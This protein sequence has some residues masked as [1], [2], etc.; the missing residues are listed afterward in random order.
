MRLL[1]VTDLWYQTYESAVDSIFK[2]YLKEFIEVQIVYLNNIES[3]DCTNE[4]ILIDKRKKRKLVNLININ[5]YEYI[6]IR[7]DFHILN[8]FLSKKLRSRTKT[9]IGFQL[10]FPHSYRRYYEAIRFK[11]S[12]LRKKIEYLLK[13]H[14]E[15]HLINKCDFFLPITREMINVF[16]SDINTKWMEVPMGID[17]EI[18]IK[19][20]YI[21][22]GMKKKFVYIG[23]L[24][25]SREF[26]I[27]LKAFESIPNK[28]WS[29]DV[30]T[31]DKEAL[32]NMVPTSTKSNVT[33][34][35][36]MK[37]EEL[38]SKLS[39][40][41]CGI[42]L[43]PDTELYSVA[44]P[45]KVMDYY[46]SGIPCIMSP[47]PEC[48]EL[49]D[50]EC[51]IFSEFRLDS[52]K[53]SILYVISKNEGDLRSMGEYGRSALLKKRNYKTISNELFK[54]IQKV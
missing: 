51:A 13:S 28:L 41:H 2:K 52:I 5:D 31:E 50:E 44:S 22:H 47:I 16:Y 45:T 25:K 39:E 42:F 14:K 38:L 9:K 34:N 53:D 10:T 29:L 6:I 11:K 26:G 54:F 37:Y 23:S 19:P 17:P 15:A 33:Y 24:E 48:K 4:Q 18:D 27:V 12:V 30:Y 20:R 36:Y 49:F 40:Y 21:R 32:K 8:D 43:L 3:F 46:L 1:Y 7:N 35:E